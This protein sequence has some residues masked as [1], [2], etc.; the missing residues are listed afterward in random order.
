MLLRASPQIYEAHICL[1][2]PEKQLD[3]YFIQESACI[4]RQNTIYLGA[5]DI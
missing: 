5:M 2:Q 3:L 4:A 1:I